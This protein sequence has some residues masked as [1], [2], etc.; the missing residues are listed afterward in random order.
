MQSAT[1]VKAEVPCKRC[2][3]SAMRKI[4]GASFKFSH[5]PDAP[6]PQNTGVSDI[7]HDVDIVIGRSAEA[8]LKEFQRRQDYKRSLIEADKVSGDHLSRLD[9]G[10]YFV[11]SDQERVAAK[12]ARLVNQ[13]VMKRVAPVVRER[14][15]KVREEEAASKSSR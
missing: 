7:D 11:M 3:K 15:K 9:N 6:A 4:S 14:M 2:K 1:N 5:R 13:D 12:K 10:E 8:N